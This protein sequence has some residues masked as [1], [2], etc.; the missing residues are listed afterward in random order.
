MEK[1][2]DVFAAAVARLHPQ[3]PP[4]SFRARLEALAG[5]TARERGTAVVEL[6]RLAALLG[7]RNGHSGIFAFDEHPQ[8]LRAYPFLPYEFED[9]L[10]VVSSPLAPRLAG[11]E[12][13]RLAGVEPRELLTAVEPL[14]PRDNEW[15]VRAR[16]PQFAVTAE[17][18]HGLGV[19]DRIGAVEVD[20]G[21]GRGRAVRLDPLPAP[22]WRERLRPDLPGSLEI[23][24]GRAED[25]HWWTTLADGRAVYTAYNVTR[26]DVTRFAGGVEDA[27]LAR[28]AEVLVLDLRR[29]GGGDN[30]TYGPVLRAAVR[31]TEAGRRLVVLIGRATFSAA[32]QLVVDL[33]QQTP[34]VFVGEPTGGSPNQFG[35][36]EAVVLPEAQLVAHVA[37]IA[38][39]TAGAD[40]T[41]LAREPDLAVP[42]ESSAFREGRDP[43][44]AA[45]LTA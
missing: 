8:P 30:R 9:G 40:D 11:R 7:P 44:L 32:M 31:A 42:V 34:A 24:P 29:N 15:T 2:A 17:V 19:I 14:V 12:V 20:C 43:A 33:E 37:T 41:R 39:T 18:L 4:A 23:L 5:A 27:M 13:R 16:R 25:A 36:A 28:P 6:M 3:P 38:W 35:D 10:V 21:P 1:D 26:G 22:E 45:A